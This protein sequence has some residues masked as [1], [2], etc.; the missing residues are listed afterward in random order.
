MPAHRASLEGTHG[1]AVSGIAYWDG[2]EACPIVFN[3]LIFLSCVNRSCL[4]ASGE[5]AACMALIGWTW[6]LKTAAAALAGGN[7][8]RAQPL[9]PRDAEMTI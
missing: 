5:A 4:A 8:G 2:T 6:V 9:S 7:H 1:I 3:P